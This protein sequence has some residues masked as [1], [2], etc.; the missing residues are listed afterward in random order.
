MYRI[1]LVCSF[2]LA[3]GTS[4]LSAPL[5]PDAVPIEVFAALPTIENPKLSPD[6]TK[7]AAKIAIQGE[8]LLVVQPLFG[9]KPAA[10]A[11]GRSD[12]NWWEWVNDNWLVVGIGEDV[13]IYG[14]DLYARQLVGVSADMKTIN[15]IDRNRNGVEADDVIWYAK[16]GSP[17]LLL[18]KSTGV[19]TAD[20]WYPSVFD[21]DVS[22]GRAK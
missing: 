19:Q 21:V 18:S 9:G 6:G 3:A 20:D 12:L 1:A 15:P 2:A 17:R 16:D 5:L 14:E 13:N 11:Q 4:A 22:T 7:V 10:M 8:Q